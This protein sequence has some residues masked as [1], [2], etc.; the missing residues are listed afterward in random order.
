MADNGDQAR[1]VVRSL[2]G[3]GKSLVPHH[4][5]FTNHNQHHRQKQQQRQA[6]QTAGTSKV[7]GGDRWRQGNR[8]GNED[9]KFPPL[10]L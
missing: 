4:L 7:N 5:T 9:R 2:I 1:R 6:R 3:T 8:K 10:F